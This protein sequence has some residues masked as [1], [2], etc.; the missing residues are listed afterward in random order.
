VSTEIKQEHP[1]EKQLTSEQQ[2]QQ[3]FAQLSAQYKTPLRNILGETQEAVQNVIS[4]L[5]GQLIQIRSNLNNSNQEVI[6]LQKL[7]TDNQV[8]FMSKS[9]NRKERREVERNQAKKD[10][11][12]NKNK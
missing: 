11:K 6:R 2:Y 10:R 5:I 8:S 1:K 9:P 7:C 3:L 12:N 4:N